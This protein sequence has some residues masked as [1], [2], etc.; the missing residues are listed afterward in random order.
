M[1]HDGHSALANH[2]HGSKSIFIGFAKFSEWVSFQNLLNFCFICLQLLTEVIRIFSSLT[3][4]TNCSS[5]QASIINNNNNN[6]LQRNFR[7]WIASEKVFSFCSIPLFQN[8]SLWGLNIDVYGL[9]SPFIWNHGSW[10]WEWEN[11]FNRNLSSNSK[12]VNLSRK[13]DE[14]IWLESW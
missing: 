2:T 6:L 13:S 5:R 3:G 12:H 1:R 8:L 10:N 9:L 7:I 4:H 14:Q 11:K